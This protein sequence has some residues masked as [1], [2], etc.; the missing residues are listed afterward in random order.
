VIGGI[1]VQQP[2]EPLPQDA[3][4]TLVAGPAYFTAMRSRTVLVCG[5]LVA[6]FGC[7]GPQPSVAPDTGGAD[8]G[9]GPPAAQ[10]APTTSGAASTVSVP[11]T[12]VFT[13]TTV[14]GKPFDAAR[15]AG[16]PVVLWFW[17]PWCGTCAGQAASVAEARARYEGK[18]SVVGVAGLGDLKAMQ[19]FVAD[20][21]VAAVPHV[22]DQAGAVWRKFGITQQSVYVFLDAGGSVVHKGWLDSVAFDERLMALAG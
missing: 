13:G 20:L 4:G 22:N 10:A 6:L 19:R 14:D 17:A 5:L 18:V 16:R 21:D 3:G 11:A 8:T 7:G 15:L 12:L 9:G 2:G 1:G